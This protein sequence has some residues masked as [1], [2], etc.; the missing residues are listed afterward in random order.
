MRLGVVVCRCGLVQ[1]LHRINKT[2]KSLKV[3]HFQIVFTKVTKRA[4]VRLSL[5]AATERKGIDCICRLVL[6]LSHLDFLLE[7]REKWKGRR[8]E[9]RLA[10]IIRKTAKGFSRKG[11]RVRQLTPACRNSRC[12]PLLMENGWRIR[13]LPGTK[14]CIVE[15]N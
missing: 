14:T 15:S 13:K 9:R 4:P 12:I 6:I 8:A 5:P 10:A 2:V 3:E 11:V 7:W 1:G